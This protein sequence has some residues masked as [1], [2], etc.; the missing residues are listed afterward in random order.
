MSFVGVST[1]AYSLPP[2]L[3][4]VNFRL[5]DNPRPRPRE[6]TWK[7]DVRVLMRV[8]EKDPGW[9]YKRGKE[10]AE[11]AREGIKQRIAQFEMEITKKLVK[12]YV[13]DAPDRTTQILAHFEPDS[14]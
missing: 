12:S 3:H 7:H 14:R 1:N 2:F 4:Q 11:E 9:S 13:E 10:R 5:V 8:Q 6:N